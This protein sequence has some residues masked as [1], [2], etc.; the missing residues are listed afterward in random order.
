MTINIW[1]LNCK[2]DS[3]L[4]AKKCHKCGC[5]LTPKNRKY[6]AIV[7]LPDGRRV[8]KM[9]DTLDLA[10]S[11]ESKFKTRVIEEDVFQVRKSPS[12]ETAWLQY[13]DWAKINKRTCQT[14]ERIW[15]IHIS[16]VLD[17]SIKM[18]KITASHVQKVIT[19]MMTSTKHNGKPYQPATVRHVLVL[20]KRVYNWAIKMDLYAGLNPPLC[21]DSCRPT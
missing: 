13:Y 4:T 7:K 20:L 18:D 11:I 14:D 10:K 19:T 16:P 9:A 21:Q 5:K 8:S 2:T 1:C 3:K 12:L 6:R 15:R 17:T